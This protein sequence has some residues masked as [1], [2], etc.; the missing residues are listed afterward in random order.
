M[1][2]SRRTSGRASGKPIPEV[3]GAVLE[4]DGVLVGFASPGDRPDILLP[5][6][7][8]LIERG[9]I[10]I[11]CATHT[12][13]GTVEVVREFGRQGFQVEWI[14]INS[15][16]GAISR[17]S[18]ASPNF[19]REIRHSGL[20]PLSETAK[21]PGRFGVNHCVRH[22]AKCPTRHPEREASKWRQ[23]G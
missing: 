8:A 19:I 15:F 2:S 16:V 3:K 23:S 4:I 22:F 12:R 17:N 5:L 18:F 10:I 14:E 1:F 21:K 6:L 7:E 20:Q 13:G 11:V 9:C